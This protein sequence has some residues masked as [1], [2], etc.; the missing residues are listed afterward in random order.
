[1]PHCV[2]DVIEML[3]PHHDSKVTDVARL[4]FKQLT[5][6]TS[7]TDPIIFI[8]LSS[9]TQKE[10]SRLVMNCL[11]KINHRSLAKNQRSI[12]IYRG[13]Y[14]EPFGTNQ[15]EKTHLSDEFSNTFV[16]QKF[17]PDF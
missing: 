13:D 17:G 12:I 11:V 4:I 16:K 3:A 1:M 7:V 9:I 8:S 10:I 14:E 2:H 6:S 5:L 15:K